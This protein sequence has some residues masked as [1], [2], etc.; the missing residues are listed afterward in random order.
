MITAATVWFIRLLLRRLESFRECRV[1][2]H[3]LVLVRL[4]LIV[5]SRC[6]IVVWLFVV[7]MLNIRV[8]V[9]RVTVWC[10]MRRSVRVTLA[11]LLHKL[12]FMGR[13]P[14]RLLLGKILI[15][16]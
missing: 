4:G 15:A 14:M 7:R 13:I 3:F 5:R 2:R 12:E 1:C 10:F 16:T 11:V 6:C 8:T 9:L